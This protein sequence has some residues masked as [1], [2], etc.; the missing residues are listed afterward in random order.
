MHMGPKASMVKFSESR[1]GAHHVAPEAMP[2]L[3]SSV[4]G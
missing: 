2:E 1:D 4:G 3:G